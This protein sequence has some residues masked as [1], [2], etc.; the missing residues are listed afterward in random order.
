[1]LAII[2]TGGKQYKISP[3]EKIKVE[4]LEIEEGKEVVFNEVLLIEDKEEVKIGTPFIEKA[5]VTG[6][7]LSQGKGKK[8]IVFKYK[9]KTRYKKKTGHRQMFT[10]VEILKINS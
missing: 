4:K 2:K 3:G 10:E 1:M 7:V 9:P 6:K 8:V 5:T